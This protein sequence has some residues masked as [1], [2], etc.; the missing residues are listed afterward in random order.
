MCIRPEDQRL[1]G[2]LDDTAGFQRALDMAA[3]Q[4]RPVC[5]EPGYVYQ[6][7]GQLNVP[8]GV[9][10]LGYGAKV[11]VV[12]STSQIYAVFYSIGSSVTIDR[13]DID[14]NYET[15]APLLGAS[16]GIRL[17]SATDCTVSHCRI[18]NT[19]QGGITFGGMR[20]SFIIDNKLVNCGSLNE[21]AEDHS[22]IVYSDGDVGAVRAVT[23]ARNVV[24]GAG[25][26]GIASYVAATAGAIESLTVA[27]NT[28]VG[29]GLGGIFLSAAP[30]RS[31]AVQTFIMVEGNT[32]RDNGNPIPADA[33]RTG[34]PSIEVDLAIGVTVTGNSSTGGNVG[35]FMNR[36]RDV[37][38][39]G[40]V[41]RATY[42]VGILIAPRA[43]EL[44]DTSTGISISG[45]VIF[46]PGIANA[47]ENLGRGMR[48]NNCNNISVIGNTIFNDG[49]T[50]DYG[51]VFED[52]SAS[53][54]SATTN[55]VAGF[56]TPFYP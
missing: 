8:S 37:A 48:L 31:E 34:G 26:K 51:V 19:M 44:R 49:P 2:D 16:Q 22:I 13:V 20:D 10:L 1:P 38:V 12:R 5:L 9:T 21:G 28:V 54:G 50:L 25:R 40:N 11:F 43:G 52:C 27:G 56:T 55:S 4:G 15:G 7:S 42:G 45:N 33:K 24:F 30:S 32:L 23:V 6:V 14:A 53:V 46:R 39:T 18:S 41:I 47:P 3:A 35:I 29:S 17:E 36:V